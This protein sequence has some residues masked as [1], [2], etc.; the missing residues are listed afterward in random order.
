MGFFAFFIQGKLKDCLHKCWLSLIIM[1]IG[2]N[3]IIIIIIIIMAELI[4]KFLLMILIF[5]IFS[6]IYYSLMVGNF[7]LLNIRIVVLNN[8]QF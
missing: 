7:I 2:I 8:F 4:L 1:I 5:K 6:L 3:I